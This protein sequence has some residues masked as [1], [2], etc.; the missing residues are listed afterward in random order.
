MLK[1]KQYAFL[2]DFKCIGDK[3]GDNCCTGWGISIEEQT[4][5]K[6]LSQAPELLD[7]LDVSNNG[8]WIMQ[9]NPSTSSC[10]Q[11]DKGWCKTHK[12]YG[13]EFL[14]NCCSFFP[15]IVRQ[16]GEEK[17]MTAKLSC[18]E[19]ARL[20]ISQKDNPFALKDSEY[21]RDFSQPEKI[22]LAGLSFD[23]VWAIHQ[24]F[25]DIAANENISAVQ[26]MLSISSVVFALEKVALNKWCAEFDNHLNDYELSPKEAALD[27]QFLLLNSLTGLL[28]ANRSG[29]KPQRLDEIINS[30]A[31]ALAVDFDYHAQGAQ[32]RTEEKS[33]E[34]LNNLQ[35]RWKNEWEAHFEPILHR[36]ISAQIAA[37]L[38]PF[39]GFG[40]GAVERMIIITVRFATL[41][42]S[43]MAQCHKILGH[44]ILGHKILGE[45]KNATLAEDDTVRIIQSLSRFFEHF[46]EFKNSMLIYNQIGWNNMARI[47]GLLEI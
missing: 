4:Y 46:N 26:A 28:G 27:D 31:D 8:G 11:F 22:S 36:W 21:L 25:L 1:V 47:R 3:C 44:K 15:R 34:A 16:V 23:D 45:Q 35:L 39:S 19:I 12:N 2:N 37:V 17:I 32:M 29:P 38:F 9:T 10:V 20:V 43:L 30:M 24:K 40:G 33:Y 13:E 14:S 42:L 18:P 41:R 5:D 6:Y 7:L